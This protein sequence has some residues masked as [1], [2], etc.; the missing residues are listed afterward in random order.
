MAYY[1]S[2]FFLSFLP[3]LSINY[4]YRGCGIGIISRPSPILT[5]SVDVQ[6]LFENG[7]GGGDIGIENNSFRCPFFFRN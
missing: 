1:F 5:W 7:G 6:S 4:N 2:S 3:S